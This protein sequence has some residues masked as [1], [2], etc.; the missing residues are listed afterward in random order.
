[1]GTKK[2]FIL[3]TNGTRNPDEGRRQPAGQIGCQLVVRPMV[4]QQACFACLVFTILA[5][6]NGLKRA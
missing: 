6:L 1:M 5:S 3:D 2:N 4:W